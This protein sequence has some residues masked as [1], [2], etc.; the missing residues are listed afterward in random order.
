MTLQYKMIETGHQAHTTLKVILFNKTFRMPYHTEYSSGQILNLID[1]DTN[2]A[3]SLLWDLSELIK[4]PFEISLASYYIFTS[5]GWSFLSSVA[6]LIT[7]SGIIYLNRNKFL[8]LDKT[9]V[10]KKDSRM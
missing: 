10:A 5:I 4:L 1:R 9:I 2:Q 7:V 6:V 3:W 8:T